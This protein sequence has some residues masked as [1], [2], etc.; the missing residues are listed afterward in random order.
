MVANSIIS[1]IMEQIDWRELRMAHFKFIASGENTL[2]LRKATKM[3]AI[4]YDK[5]PDTYTV[6]TYSRSRQDSHRS[7]MMWTDLRPAIQSHF[8]FEYVMRGIKIKYLNQNLA[9]TRRR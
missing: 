1:T 7:G 8:K 2:I 5:G 9:A 3:M 4:R 6:D